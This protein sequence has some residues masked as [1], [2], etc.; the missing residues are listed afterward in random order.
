MIT[1]RPQPLREI[2]IAIPGLPHDL[3]RMHQCVWD[4]AERAA[5]PGKPPLFLYRVENGMVQVRGRDFRKGIVREFNAQR[6][7]RLDIAA[8]KRS[9]VAGQTAVPASE[10][11]DWCVGALAK[12]GFA[13]RELAVES[14]GVQ[15]GIKRD[16]NTG[17]RHLIELPVARLSLRL[18]VL[19]QDLANA[20]WADGIGRGRRFGLGMLCH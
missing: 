15:R 10:L 3:Y 8:V 2:L 12:A 19:D 18:D 7:F 17:R 20:A 9:S 11:D 1:A 6:A 5:R 16:R 13:V 4:H 14:Y